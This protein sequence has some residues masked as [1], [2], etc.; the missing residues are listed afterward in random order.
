VTRPSRIHVEGGF[1]HVYNRL[2]RGESVFS[3]KEEAGEFV[4][5]SNQGALSPLPPSA[6]GWKLQTCNPREGER[7]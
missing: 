5:K 6:W 1:Y 2:G 3:A 4:R 7:T